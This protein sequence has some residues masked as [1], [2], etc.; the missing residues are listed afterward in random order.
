M[1]PPHLNELPFLAAGNFP[2]AL[3]IVIFDAAVGSPR[4]FKLKDDLST[5]R[6]K[7]GV[8]MIQLCKYWALDD[9]VLDVRSRVLKAAA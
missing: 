2:S 5:G 9:R 1:C 4:Q 6:P 7:I 3:Y 8:L